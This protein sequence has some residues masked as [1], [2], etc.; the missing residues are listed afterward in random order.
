M[1]FDGVF[2][3]KKWC[4]EEERFF[5]FSKFLDQAILKVFIRVESFLFWI[6][7]IFFMYIYQEICFSRNVGNWSCQLLE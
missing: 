2:Y 7:D 3:I 4:A 1:S 5:Q 6:T